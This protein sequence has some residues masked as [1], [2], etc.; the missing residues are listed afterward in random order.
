MRGRVVQKSIFGF[1]FKYSRKDQLLLLAV[2]FASFPPLYLS[3]DLPKRIIN[4]AIN[5]RDFPV[6]FLWMELDQ[7]PFLMLLCFLFLALVMVNGAFKYCINLWKGRLGERMLRR[8]RYDLYSRILRFPLLHFRRVGPGEIIPMITAETEPLGGFVGDAVAQPVFQAGQLLTILAFIVVQDPILG[9]AAVSLYPFQG[10]LVPRLQRRVNALGK[11]RIRVMRRV[12]DRISKSITG[13][14]ELRAHDATNHQR[15]LFTDLMARI[16]EIRF[17]V[18]R[19]K[20]FIKFLNNFLAQLT[21]FFFYS[22]GGYLVIHGQLSFGALVAVLAAYKDMSAPWK[23][24]LTWYQQ[25]EDARIKYEQVVEQFELSGMLSEEHQLAEPEQ[26]APLPHDGEVTAVNVGYIDDSGRPLVESVG[27]RFRLDEHVAIVGP[28][29]G[30][31]EELTM[32]LARLLMPTTGWIT[33]AGTDLAEL[34]EAITGRRMAYVGHGAYVF[35][36]TIRDNLLF[37][38]RHRPLRPLPPDDPRSSERAAAIAQAR[39]AGNSVDD[40][41]ADWIDYEGVGLADREALITRIGAV[42][43]MVELSSDIYGLGLRGSVDSQPEMAERIL[44]ARRTLHERLKAPGIEGLIEPFDPE[45]Y[46]QNATLAENLLFGTPVG[47]IFQVDQLTDNGYVLDILERTG[48]REELIEV[49]RQVAELMVELFGDLDPGQELFER[50]SFISA[51]DLPLFQGIIARYSR[52][53]AS[54]MTPDDRAKLLALP[55]RLVPARHR[56]GLLEGPIQERILEARRLFAAELPE[57]MRS[58]IE[59]FDAGRYNAAASIQDNILF[60]KIAYDRPQ[61]AAKI[62]DLLATIVDEVGILRDVM[63]VGISFEVGIG[64]GR[65]SGTQRQKLAIARCLLKRPDLF[66]IN[67]ALAALDGGARQRILDAIREDMK[68]RGDRM[69]AR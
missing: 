23:E 16:Y 33:I 36:G 26:L 7:I 2:T 30:G 56:L 47:P 65:L 58:A 18:Y 68:G 32:L 64:G 53:G 59:F 67:G 46:N 11:E 10:W 13:I 48:L 31:K 66:L 42:L 24:L 22:I 38:L 25:K 4:S 44:S 57:E 50:Y 43:G 21:P 6:E 40:T 45:R 49:G 12:S 19:R 5:G 61:S 17:E 55:L 27:F 35:G 62:H 3:L 14:T 29:G 34:P 51:D 15:A 39:R 9:I 60:G 54:A 69:C 1:V 20:F 37:G 28:G 41:A 8:L 52:G 63:T